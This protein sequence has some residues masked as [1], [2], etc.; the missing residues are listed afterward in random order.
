[1]GGSALTFQPQLGLRNS[2]QLQM[3]RAEVLRQRQVPRTW[4]ATCF[5]RRTDRKLRAC[6]ERL[7]GW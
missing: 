7:A 3:I 5:W 2:R 1:M 6:T 4:P